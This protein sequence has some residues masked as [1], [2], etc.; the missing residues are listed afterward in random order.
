MYHIPFAESPAYPIAILVKPSALREAELR[1]AYVD[2]LMNLGV[3]EGDVIAFTLEYNDAGKAPVNQVIKPYLDLLLPTLKEVGTKYLYVND[4]SYFKT[5]TKQATAEPHQGY[6][7]PCAIKGF[8][9][10]SVVLGTNYQALFYKPDLQDKLDRSLEVMVDHYK[11]S[12]VPVGSD[13]IQKEYYPETESDIAAALQELHKYPE[14]SGDIEAFSLRFHEAGIA[15]IGFAPTKHEGIAFACD[16]KPIA[17]LDKLHGI[18]QANPAVRKLI[19]E[20]LEIYQ[21]TITWH[22]SAYDLKVLIYTLWMDSPLDQAGL[23][24]GLHVLTKNFHDTKIIAYLA[25]NSTARNSYGLK[26]MAHEFAGNWAQADIKDVRKIP[27]DKLLRYN[28]VDCLSTNFVKEKYWDRMVEDQQLNIYNNLMIPSLKVII[29]MELSGMPMNMVTVHTKKAEMVA[30]EQ[31][32]LAIIDNHPLV[33]ELNGYIRE[34]ALLKRQSKLKTKIACIEEFD[35]LKFNPNSNKQLQALL[36]SFMAL[37]V[38]DVTDTKQ[39]STGD[40]TLKKLLNHTDNVSYKELIV[41]LRNLGKVSKVLGTFIPAFEKS[42]SKEDGWHYLHGSFNLG[43]TVSGR[44]SSS[45][46]NL[47]NIPA[48]SLY[49]KAIKECFQAPPGWL[50]CG[51]DFASLEDRISAL[52]TKDPNKLKVYTDGYDGHCLRAFTYFGDQMIGIDPDSVESINSIEH[53]YKGLRQESKAPTFALTYQGTWKTLVNNCGFPAS[54]AK[55]VEKKYHELYK[56][57][58]DYIDGK[59]EQAT[60]DGYVTAAFGLRVRTPLLGQVIWDKANMPYEAAAEGRTAGNA[61][62]QS[63]CLLNNRAVN[64]FM[65]EVWASPYV[66]DIKPVACIHDAIYVMVRDVPEI[67]AWVNEALTRA[68]QWQDLEEIKHPEVTLGGALDIFWPTWAQS[69]TLPEIA[70]TQEIIDVCKKHKDKILN[71]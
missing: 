46:P 39:P 30:E 25:L 3:P 42:L 10:M 6:V 71:P 60:K 31:R 7:L 45:D 41:A 68:M 29:Q 14:I 11:G 52:T 56:V 53:L 57:S 21:G 15:T 66:L 49:G 47:Q 20:F 58:D 9:D 48:G 43:G 17:I 33:K 40:D 19:R 32:C 5:L 13:I 24:K 35:E 69:V 28:L 67:V 51:A 64:A 59:L 2:P 62:G 70:T 23:L 50:F 16:Y 8:E 36:Y 38:I 37:P 34:N 18:Q 26:D 65:E 54:K 12:Y 27:L 4:G 1:R 55:M 22:N 44:L 63:Y 61:L